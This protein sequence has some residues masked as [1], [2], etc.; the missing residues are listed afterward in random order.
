MATETL[1]IISSTTSLV[2][3]FVS[4]RLGKSWLFSSIVL[5]LILVSIFGVKLVSVF[6]WVT[7]VGNIFY[8]CVFLATYFLVEKYGKEVAI[9]TVWHGLYYIISFYLAS[10]FIV[11]LD[12]LTENDQVNNAI[13][14]IFLAS[15]RIMLGSMLA[16][17][18]AQNV[19]VII[20]DWLK[21]KFYDKFLFLRANVANI[22]SQLFD[23]AIFFSIAFFDLSGAI[24]LQAILVGSAIKIAVVLLGTPLLY[25][26]SYLNKRNHV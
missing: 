9:Q 1:L 25:L 11:S 14:V 15:P 16:Y 10:Y 2:L 4:A 20:Y 12:G 17:I 3:V 18:F 26:D 5:N 13:K 22:L 19:N 21:K 23:S 6:G 7:N 24:L 8:A